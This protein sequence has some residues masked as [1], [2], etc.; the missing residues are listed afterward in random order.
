MSLLFLFYWMGTG[1]LAIGLGHPE[2]DE[3][4]H[5]LIESHACSTPQITRRTLI[6][7]FDELSQAHTCMMK[8][9]AL[10]VNNQTLRPRWVNLIL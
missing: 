2:G 8:L 7:T 1:C 3:T 6:A 5:G 10:F 4:I 9:H